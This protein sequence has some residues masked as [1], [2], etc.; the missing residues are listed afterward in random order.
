[1]SDDQHRFLSLLAQ[2]P[3]RFTAQ[4]TAWALNIQLYDIP[5]LIA[6]RLLKPLGSPAPNGAKW[7]A[8]AEIQALSRDGA[9]LSKA[10][11]VLQD[12]WQVRNQKRA[13]S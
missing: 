13:L 12:Y 8:A 3:A 2:P 7:F 6:K 5:I 4:Q 1:M 11:K 9:W 10:T